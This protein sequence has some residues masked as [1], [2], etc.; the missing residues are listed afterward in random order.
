MEKHIF[1]QDQCLGL[2]NA[3]L[4]LKHT[5]TY[6]VTGGQPTFAN[7]YT[8][9]LLNVLPKAMRVNGVACTLVLIRVFIPE[10]RHDPEQPFVGWIWEAGYSASCSDDFEIVGLGEDLA[11]ALCGLYLNLHDEGY[12]GNDDEDND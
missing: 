9:D 10:D 1:T 8:T 11:D 4:S 3:G 6:L 12:L 5:N 7:F 2:Y